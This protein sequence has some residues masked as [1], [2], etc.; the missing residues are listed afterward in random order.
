MAGTLSA[1][2]SLVL[3]ASRSHDPNHLDDT[4][5]YTWTCTVLDEAGAPSTDC[6]LSAAA[7]SALTPGQALVTLPPSSIAPPQTSLRFDVT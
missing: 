5:E 1:A 3:D 4:A 6:D 7:L 2:S